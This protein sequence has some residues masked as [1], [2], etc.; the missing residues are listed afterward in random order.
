MI[1]VLHLWLSNFEK[2]DESFSARE[3]GYFWW[4][5]NIED[6]FSPMQIPSLD[7]LLKKDASK[8]A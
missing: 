2:N 3:N 1:K 4:I 6:S 5:N 8:S 7:V